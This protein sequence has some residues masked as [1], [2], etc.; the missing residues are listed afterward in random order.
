MSLYFACLAFSPLHLALPNTTTLFSLEKIITVLYSILYFSWTP[1]VFIKYINYHIHKVLILI[2]I[3]TI[4]HTFQIAKQKFSVRWF[5]KT[6]QNI[7]SGQG[8]NPLWC[9]RPTYSPPPHVLKRG[10]QG[11]E[12]R[13][14]VD[15]SLNMVSLSFFICRGGIISHQ[16]I[17]NSIEIMYT[18]YPSSFNLKLNG[19]S[20]TLKTRYQPPVKHTEPSL[21][22]SYHSCN[23][24]VIYDLFAVVSISLVRLWVPWRRLC[25]CLIPCLIQCLE[26]WLPRLGVQSLLKKLVD[27][28]I[29]DGEWTS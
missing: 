17:E 3:I 4:G 6:A 7:K 16:V 21:H 10:H 22:S 20:L 18:S 19:I 5:Y 26:Q 29:N 11:S 14:R 23:H 13:L 25:V 27:E 15:R 9:P 28:G 2:Q 24:V 8:K 12:L 1:L